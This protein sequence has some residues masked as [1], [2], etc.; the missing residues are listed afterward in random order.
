MISGLFDPYLVFY[1]DEIRFTLSDCGNIQN[2]CC[3]GAE[4]PHSVHDSLEVGV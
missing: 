3:W 1:S 2:S 4:N